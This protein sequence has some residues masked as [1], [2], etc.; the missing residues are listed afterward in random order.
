MP[1]T[2][3]QKEQ[4]KNYLG[5]SDIAALFGL[6]P[7][8]TAYDVY[9]EKTGKLDPAKQETDYQN[10]GNEFEPIL[11]NRAERDIGK[12]LR[13]Q[14][15]SARKAGLP[16]GS[17]I[18]GI[19][20]EQQERPVEAKCSGVF[21]PVDER[22]G[23]PGTDEVP[24]RVILQCQTHL[25]CTDKDLCYVPVLM[26][27]AKYAMYVIGR[28]ESVINHIC[29]TAVKFWNT[30]V[31]TDTPPT[32]SYPSLPIITQIHREPETIVTVPDELVEDW[33]N[34]KAAESAA[35]KAKETDWQKLAAAMGTAEA[36]R[37]STGLVTY[38]QQSNSGYT[39]QPFTCRIARYKE[40]KE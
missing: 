24:D 12:I 27:G 13:N 14:F 30:C 23:E 11:L 33:L 37:C 9:L 40:K 2:T 29:E 4:R 38:K 22:W 8:A 21:W 31:K 28:D 10:L 1:I 39:V 5:S 25:I 34:A 7:F 32:D 26:R 35:K 18:D 3:I 15:R 20:T 16:I 19:A 17:H 36:A 6:S